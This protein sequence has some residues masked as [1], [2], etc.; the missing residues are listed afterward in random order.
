M[1]NFSAYYRLARFDKPIGIVLL[2]APVM[3]ALW[4]ANR[5]MPSIYLLVLFLVG[6]VLTRA[7][8]CVINDI[9]D[10]RIDPLVART[11]QRPLATQVLSTTE[12]S[13][14]VIILLLAA[15]LILIL[16]PWECFIYALIAVLLM[17][18]YPFCKRF[19]NAPQFILG[20]AFSMS[21]PMAYVASGRAFEGVMYWLWLI[22]MFWTI[23]Y[24]TQYALVDKDD[25]LKIGVKSTAILF[26]S[27][28]LEIISALQLIIQGLW[29]VIA[30]LRDFNGLFYVFWLAASAVF[31]YQYRLL[32]KNNKALF[33]KA[34][35][36]NAYY[37]LLM[38]LALAVLN[39]KPH[40]YFH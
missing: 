19:F 39:L 18:V 35:M 6:T 34:F 25:D 29:L 26:G 2:A 5:G 36:S 14:F 28:W 22:N 38:W 33:F 20:L 30:L 17:V 32:K 8:G 3:W 12:A 10:R 40:L 11:Q 9:A 7:A 1:L 37:G 15:L 27:N 13:I 4:L 21:I 16:L 24:D 23:A 31:F